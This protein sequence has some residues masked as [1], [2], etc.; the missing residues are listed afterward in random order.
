MLS[1]KMA[2]TAFV[3]VAVHLALAILGEGGFDAFFSHGALAALAL[4]TLAALVASLFSQVNLNAGERE[5]RA[6]RWVIPAFGALGLA[7][8][9]APAYADRIGLLVFGGE[10]LRWFGVVLYVAGGVLRLV[11]IF[12][13][14]ERFSGL[15]A[16]QPGHRLKTDGLYAVVR[17][18]SYLGLLVLSFGWALAFRSLVGIVVAALFAIPLH[19]C[20][21]A[22]ERLL[23]ERFG[24]EYEA[25]RKRTWRLVPWLYRGAARS[26]SDWREKSLPLE[27][28]ALK[29]NRLRRHCEFGAG[30]GPT[31]LNE[32]GGDDFWIWVFFAAFGKRS[33][34]H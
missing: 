16:I 25:Y 8:A 13:L 12:A 34:S 15:A 33:A 19:A 26:L 6:N 21:N 9:I 3:S 23:A 24:A 18:P 5:D 20:M 28:D 32:T 14:G 1:P 4:V 31:R 7:L 17:N 29:S 10:S 30:L 2:T 27:H 22:E 11:P